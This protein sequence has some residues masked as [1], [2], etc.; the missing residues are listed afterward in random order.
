MY[1]VGILVSDLVASLAT[2]PFS[3]YHFNR[4][5]LFTTL[6]NLMAGP[7]IGLL[8]MPFTLFSLL[9]MPLGLEYWPL[10]L[11]GYG[12]RLV[13]DITAYVSSLP[14]AGYQVLSMPLWGLLMMVFGGLWLAIWQTSWRKWGWLFVVGVLLSVFTV[15]TPDILVNTEQDLIALRDNRGHLVL[16]L[17]HI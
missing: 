8:I 13:N 17:I 5:A 4:I 15:R 10:R 11:V 7:I 9:L 2:L 12:I 6:A 14:S 1:I 16:S 3:V